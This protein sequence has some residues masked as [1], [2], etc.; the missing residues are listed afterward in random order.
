M[1]TALILLIILLIA[2][3]CTAKSLHKQWEKAELEDREEEINNVLQEVETTSNNY[4]KIRKINI[5][6][7]R[8][9][10]EKINQTL[11]L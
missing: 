11:N 7:T 6:K 1:I 9:Q 5:N 3:L 10:K 2:G 8:K 4:K